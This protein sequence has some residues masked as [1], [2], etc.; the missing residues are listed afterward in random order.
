MIDKVTIAV[1]AME[2]M[3]TFYAAVLGI[4][5]T[6]REMFERTLYAGR[7]GHVERIWPAWTPR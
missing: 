6:P 4:E 5:L 2:A 7:L 1:G 3:V